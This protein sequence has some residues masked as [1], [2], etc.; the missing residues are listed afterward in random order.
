MSSITTTT[1]VVIALTLLVA[2]F[3]HNSDAI[4]CWQCNSISNQ[5]CDQ[6]PNGPVANVSKIPGC[7]Q[8]LYKECKSD[9]ERLPYTFCRTQHQTIKGEK[10]V[11]RGCGYDKVEVDC[12]VTK[13]PSVQTKVCQC[14]TDGCNSSTSI[15][16]G[17]ITILAAF[18]INRLLLH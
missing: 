16:L 18:I 9:D 6:V 12:Y 7:L 11:I 3:V 4:Y 8:D 15:T 14:F 2:L 10:R 1:K 17:S 13:T 5:F